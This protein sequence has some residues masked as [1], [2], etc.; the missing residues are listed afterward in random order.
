MHQF[1]FKAQRLIGD[2]SE[3]DIEEINFLCKVATWLL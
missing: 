3:D 1:L 2:Y